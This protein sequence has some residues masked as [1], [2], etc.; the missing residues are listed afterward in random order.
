MKSN[1]AARAN[2]FGVRHLGSLEVR[3]CSVAPSRPHPFP[4]TTRS[5]SLTGER[6]HHACRL[7]R[8]ETNL[9]RPHHRGL[10]KLG[11]SPS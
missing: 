3:G 10:S 9:F 5:T 2:R 7:P 6:P 11:P 8:P 4:T 1:E